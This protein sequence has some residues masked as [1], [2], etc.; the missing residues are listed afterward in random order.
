MLMRNMLIVMLPLALLVS[1]VALEEE[2]ACQGS[3][4]TPSLGAW[5][6]LQIS[7]KDKTF[8]ALTNDLELAHARI[9]ELENQVELLKR[10][11]GQTSD[12]GKK[13]QTGL[14][15]NIQVAAYPFEQ[16]FASLT[17]PPSE[18]WIEVGSN[19]R[20]MLRD[21][22]SMT[23]AFAKGAVL[24]SFEP[25][26]DKYAVLMSQYGGTA[27]THRKL[28]F[29]HDRGLVFPFAVGCEGS[30]E[31]HVAHVDGCSSVLPM[32]E[33]TFKADQKAAEKW[34]GWVAENC[35]KANETRVVPCVS[36]EQVIGE[37]LGGKD[38]THAKV[39]AQGFDLNVVKSAGK[40]INKLKSV[41]MEVQCDTA[42]MLY[43]GQP[44]CTSVYAEMTN[45]GFQTTFD[46]QVCMTCT[47]IDIDFTHP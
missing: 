37:W 5:S 36:L 33:E 23:A 41:H 17:P 18:F 12:I 42:A 38:I 11:Q 19:S 46:P 6:M 3:G 8:Q 13:A 25:L 39:D 4:S 16:N 1:A 9:Q 2:K 7:V 44:N 10:V 27:D 30:A 40:H 28:G 22:P 47:E 14:F 31:F 43:K 45:L 35:A 26:L 34:P 20:N 21:D 29:Q 24:L 32:A 15:A